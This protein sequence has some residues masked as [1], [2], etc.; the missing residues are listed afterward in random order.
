MPNLYNGTFQPFKKP[1]TTQSRDN[2]TEAQQVPADSASKDALQTSAAQSAS[3]VAALRR[4]AI[5][6]S[7]GALLFLLLVGLG[8]ALM[9]FLP[10][11]TVSFA[12]GRTQWAGD[13]Q[14]ALQFTPNPPTFSSVPATL[15]QMTIRGRDGQTIDGARVQL[16]LTMATMDMGVNETSAQW[17]GQGHY[18]T[19]VAFVMPGSWQVTV[20]VVLSDGSV[21]S[22]IFDVDVAN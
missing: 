8:D 18:Q 21:T 4:R 15:V 16:S 5:I 10:R 19:R 7:L 22:T 6:V 11:T 2:K 20:R 13:L 1:M 3:G 17:L 14:V 12:N 9:G